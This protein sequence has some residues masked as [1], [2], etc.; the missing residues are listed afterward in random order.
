MAILY[1]RGSAVEYGE[2]WWSHFNP[3]F[4]SFPVD[5]TNF[6]S[7]CLWA[8]HMPMDHASD[9]E[10]GWWYQGDGTDKD[11]YS[12][13][14]AASHSFRWYFGSQRGVQLAQVVS[15]CW[16]L[17]PGDVICYDWTGDGLWQHNAIVVACDRTGQ[18]L[19]N[20]HTPNCYHKNWR[21]QDTELWT[22]NTAYLFLK[23][24][25]NFNLPSMANKEE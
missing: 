22:E 24:K 21:L 4:L 11:S 3:G 17:E 14:W 23:I 16:Q 9:M 12:F 7:Q 6:V 2:K 19:V 5:G 20:S 1:D 10:A 15:E 8:G 13:S 18:P 25:D